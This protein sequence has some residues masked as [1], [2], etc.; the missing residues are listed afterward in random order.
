M[1]A[2]PYTVRISIPGEPSHVIPVIAHGPM[3]AVS[4]VI[5]DQRQ[6]PRGSRLWEAMI[7]CRSGWDLPSGWPSPSLTPVGMA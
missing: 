5:A 2:A 7:S 3:S 6:G 4:A 1:S